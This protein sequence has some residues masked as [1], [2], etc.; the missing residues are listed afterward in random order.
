MT[1]LSPGKVILLASALQLAAGCAFISDGEHAD[2]IDADGDGIPW[3]EDCDDADPAP[4]DTGGGATTTA[5]VTTDLD[6]DGHTADVE[7]DDADPASH[8]GA[9]E[10]CDEADNDCDGEIDEGLTSV[11]YV[12]E[13]GDGAGV[14][15]VEAC[16]QPAGTATEAG[17]CDDTDRAISPWATEICDGIDNDCDDEVDGNGAVD[18][19]VWYADADSDGYGDATITAE[20]CEVPSGYVA[21]DTDCDDDAG[22]VNPGSSEYCN[23]FDDDCDEEIDESSA[24]DALTWYDDADGDG[25]GDALS[26]TIACELPLGAVANGSDCDD[27]DATI[28]PDA[29]ER[30]GGGDED[31]DGTTDESDAINASTWTVDADTDGHGAIGGRTTVGCEEPP[32]FAATD[33]D[34]DD[35]DPTVNPSAAETW[36]DGANT[37]C[38]AGSDF[39]ADSDGWGSAD[40]D[41]EVAAEGLVDIGDCDDTDAAVN[42]GATET[43]YDNID[44]DCDGGNDNDA[45][46]DGWDSEDHGGEDCDDGDATINP[47]GVDT[48]YDGVDTDCDRASDYDADADGYDSDAWGGD[49]CDDENPQ[50]SPAVADTWYDG[51]DTNCDGASDYDADSDGYD[52][53]DQGGDDCDDADSSVSP[54]AAEV[55]YEGVDTNC[56]AAN[57]Y[58]ADSDGYVSDDGG[59]DDCIDTNAGVSP[60]ATETWY[61]GVDL[62]CD[63]ASDYDADADGYDSDA[64]GGDDCDDTD[65]AVSPSVTEVWYDGTDSDCDGA[66]DYDADSDG[67]EADVYGGTDC[68]DADSAVS[69][70]ASEIWYDGLDADC[71][72]ASDYDADS[73]G[74][75]AEDWGGDDCVDTDA[76]ANPAAT[77]VW[78]DGVDSDCDGSDD[79]DADGDGAQSS[80]H[81]GT[82]CDDTDAAMPPGCVTDLADA[83]YAFIGEADDDYAGRAV[84]G[85][86]DVDG[87]GLD[88]LLIG[89]YGNDDQGAQAGKAYLVLGGTLSGALSAAD[90][91]FEGE[92]GGD[93]AGYAIAGAGDVD[94]DGLDDLLI[95]AYG[96]DDGGSGSDSAGK[97]ALFLGGA[98]SVGT[99]DLSLADSTFLG[100]SDED[101]AGWSVAGPGDI[102][103]DGL[104]DLLIGARY[105]DADGTNRGVAYVV[106]GVATGS[107]TLSG[108]DH[109][110]YGESD[111]DLAGWAVAGAG[112]VDGDGLADLLVSA[113][114]DD[115]G[116]S[117]AGRVYLIEA[118]SLGG[119]TSLGSAD[120]FYG[121]AADDGAGWAVAGAGD[122]DGDGLD[123]VL[124]GAY[125]NDDGG[126]LAGKAYLIY[127]SAMG[128]GSNS[129]ASASVGIIGE[130]AGD[131]A[132]RS[133]AGAGD[134]DGDG[135][136]DLLVGANGNNDG[137]SGTNDAGKAYLILANTLDGSGSMGLADS[138]HALVGESNSDYAGWSVAGAGDV[139]G[140]GLADLLIGAYGNDDGGSG[141]NDAGKV[142]LSLVPW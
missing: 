91:T 83:E 6:G 37:N 88:D 25:F 114:G 71:D 141:S 75:L 24:I 93:Y 118:S 81:G 120:S 73:D 135:L 77:D 124:I 138:H 140:D 129:L 101:N 26:A 109:M 86:G 22:A 32:G 63:G 128:G 130:A 8:I 58:D 72:G 16:T 67:Y 90:V 97:A 111:E 70:G 5:P 29:W 87:D 34:C 119:S 19:S 99:L 76:S 126:S 53:E 103:G 68:D 23:G 17:D 59:G 107:T 79:Y 85:A 47:D 96:N 121:E 3:P 69:P 117:E 44:S 61:D 46:S 2:R 42:P 137:G 49:D 1:L 94:G 60:E 106:A 7:C 78:Y 84:T 108:A 21:D 66:S 48:W 131:Y 30:C 89:A 116:G 9:T 31:C 54:A 136:T 39:D 55:W 11:W 51:V 98:L 36:Y 43:W 18:G 65:R 35:T 4:C 92:S 12:D 52:A 95:G 10:I 139:D 133:V 14:A 13:D 20:A 105:Y 41:A 50:V 113:S 122:V 27:T 142:Y 57:D 123:D 110:L 28:N 33:D 40:H 115:D 127:A 82:D 134:V 56:D 102:D 62:D 125:G 64:W 112:D 100:E 74:Y 45:D 38:D 15:P 132:G 80:D 104:A